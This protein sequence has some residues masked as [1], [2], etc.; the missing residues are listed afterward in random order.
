MQTYTKQTLKIFWQHALKYKKA[1]IITVL[2]I[3]IGDIF[4]MITPFWYKLF[5]DEIAGNG[6]IS[7]LYSLLITIGIIHLVHWGC[8]RVAA[9][10]NSYFQTNVMSDL[11]VTCFKYLHKHSFSFFNN[12]FV[13]SLVKRANRYSRAFEV[14]ADKLY[15]ELLPIFVSVAMALIILGLRQIWLAVIFGVWGIV[16]VIFN[17]LYSLY[18]L[19]YDLQRAEL[20]TKVTAHLA[21]T[22]TNQSNVKLFNGY[23]AETQGYADITSERQ[24]LWRFTWDLG[25]LADSFIWFTIIVIE[26]I[27]IY[28]S[29]GFWQEGILTPGDFVLIQSYVVLVSEKMWGLGRVIRDMYENLADANEM[30]EILLT[31]H[32][33]VDAKNAQPLNVTKG[34]VEFK[35][36]T[37]AYNKTRGV[38]H[39][40]SLVI[41]PNEKIA[42]VGHSGAGKST[43]V[44]LLLRNYDVTAGKV[45]IDGQQIAKVTLESL[46][47]NVSYVPQDPILFH[48]TLMENIRYARPD[49]SDEEVI[50]AAK[51]AH[52]HEFILE[53]SEGYDTYVGER[54]VKL[55]GGE[56]QRVAIAR[57]VLK[58]AR[59]L[60][61]DEAT[62]S[63]DS[64]SEQL[65]QDALETLMKDKT[66]IVIAHRLST[67]MKMDRVLVMEKGQIIE[68]GSHKQLLKKKNGYYKKLWDIQAGDFIK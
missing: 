62:S 11:A 37:F 13:G 22:V 10:V 27:L 61:L 52:A 47:H 29:I 23:N 33:I 36:V 38:I 43:I 32:S 28:L 9:F 15:W 21:D 66:V 34:Q 60:I 56:R 39:N 57:A 30:T 48:R 6:D 2:A 65:I 50:D 68:E 41:K 45:L 18:K 67:I 3:L 51:A 7:V 5:F 54:G 19:R 35:D 17:Y 8:I 64:E 55:S 16:L 42:L 4:K 40:L 59:I 53:L 63:L 49:A 26:I 25:T 1:L 12:S 44:K 58:N 20:D 24:K 14:V 31:P 46:W